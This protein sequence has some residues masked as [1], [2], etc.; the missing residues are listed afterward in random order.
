MRLE[1]ERLNKSFDLPG[2]VLRRRRIG[3]LREVSLSIASGEVLG[4]V[5]ESGS[6]KTTLARCI[7]G[8]LRPDSGAIRLDGVDAAS[9]GRRALRHW[10]RDMAVVYQNPFLSLNPT[11]TIQEIVTE[12]ILVRERIARATLQD[13]VSD[14]LEE[15]GLGNSILKRRVGALSGGQAQRVA[16]ARAIATRPRLIIL[17]EPS[18]SLDVRVQAQILN[19]LVD[20]QERDGF[21]CLFITH[22][23]DVVR[24]ATDRVAVMEKGI[25]VEEG[26]TE[27]VLDAPA[28]SY[29]AS[30]VAATPRLHSGSDAQA[31]TRIR[32]E[33]G[34]S[35]A[36]R[37]NSGQRPVDR[38]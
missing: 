3:V 19:L 38:C 7:M 32:F 8:I 33:P 14:L 10:R 23:L 4:L 2:G 24:F 5:G 31:A 37:V 16:I 9:L 22:D 36:C 20:L 26:D 34:A 29:T 21:S 13:R 27:R 12:P 28:H 1:V 25:I 30:L 35:S 6:G 11:M 18:S 17:D 15:V